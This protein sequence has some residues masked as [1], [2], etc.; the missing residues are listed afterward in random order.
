MTTSRNAALWRDEIAGRL[1]GVAAKV[2]DH[3]PAPGTAAPPYLTVWLDGATRFDWLFE[4]RLYGD[5][6]VNPRRTQTQ[7]ADLAEDVDLLLPP[8]PATDGFT[9]RW[10]EFSQSQGLLVYLWPVRVPRSWPEG[11]S[12]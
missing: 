1:Q 2:F 9:V 11:I 7:M 5:P 10:V 8:F 12:R 4:V 6:G 3:E